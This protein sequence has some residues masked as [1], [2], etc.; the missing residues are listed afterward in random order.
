MNII[1][2]GDPEITK[3]CSILYTCD[4]C[5]CE[6]TAVA[7]DVYVLPAEPDPVKR[8]KNI[9]EDVKTENIFKVHCPDC[10]KILSKTTAEVDAYEEEI[11]KESD[12]L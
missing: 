9:L 12:Q 11:K 7:G 8:L 6:F 10:G 5:R 2:H 1:K 4:R 3:Q